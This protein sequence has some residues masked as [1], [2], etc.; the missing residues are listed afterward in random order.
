VHANNLVSCLHD[1]QVDRTSQ[2]LPDKTLA[3][4]L[5]PNQPTGLALDLREL[6]GRPQGIYRVEA[7]ASQ[8]HWRRDSIVVTVTDLA[9]TA[10][11]LRDGYWVW[12]TSLQS[13]RPVRDVVVNGLTYNNQRVAT[14]RTDPN[15]IARLEFAAAGPDGGIWVIT[16]SHRGDESYLVPSQNQWMLDGPEQS[17]R[18]YAGHYEAMLYTDRG[19]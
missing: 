2:R 14:A 18:A 11:R 15:G 1:A 8:N 9:I 4:R 16:A 6:L 5:P 19:V 10:K 13:G 3:V 7:K 12:I 17:G